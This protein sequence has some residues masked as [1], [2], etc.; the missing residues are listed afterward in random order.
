MRL[1]KSFWKKCPVPYIYK[2]VRHSK[3]NMAECRQERTYCAGFAGFNSE[4][5]LSTGS[6]E[7]DKPA[8]TE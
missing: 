6:L 2:Q 3:N 7:N 1:K 8:P 4:D 5:S